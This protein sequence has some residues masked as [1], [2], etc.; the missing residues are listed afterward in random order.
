[1]NILKVEGQSELNYMNQNEH[2]KSRITIGK[3]G[4]V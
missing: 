4:K 2:F 1:M 3:E